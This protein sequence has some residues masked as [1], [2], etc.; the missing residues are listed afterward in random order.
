MEI[1][2]ENGVA[3]YREIPHRDGHGFYWV[4]E[5]MRP[6]PEEPR[7]VQMPG[8][9]ITSPL[10]GDLLKRALENGGKLL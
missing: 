3:I 5:G 1:P 6:A 2:I 10:S 7:R 9:N 8:G 4:L